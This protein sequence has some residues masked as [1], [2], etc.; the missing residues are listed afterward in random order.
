MLFETFLNAFITLLVITD[1]LGTAAVFAGL[2][3]GQEGAKI[4]AMALKATLIA[5]CLLI[6]FS[7]LGAPLL[8]QLGITIP[9][10]RVA[11]GLLLFVTAFRMLFGDHDPQSLKQE[12]GAYG[13]R[14]DI[15]VFPI[16]IPLLSGPG[17]LTAVILLASKAQEQ[18]GGHAALVAA[19]VAVSAVTLLCLM[20]A[21]TAQKFIG[22]SGL[23]VL[24]RVMG[25][26]LAAMSV[27]FIADGVRGMNFH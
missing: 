5:F 20:G 4:K 21:G 22:R 25:V 26:V 18:T 24:S 7:F 16:A 15:A 1:P 11:G 10:F 14:S 27:Q 13:D 12:E 2:V 6:F 19:M 8:T 23:N 17:C 9:A 3:I